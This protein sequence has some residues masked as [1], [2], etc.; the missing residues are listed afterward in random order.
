MMKR[1]TP[2]GISAHVKHHDS[3]ET[4]AAIL[5]AAGQIYAEYG[6]AGARTDAIAA[7][8]G[9]N[10]ALLYYYFQSKDELYQAV[11]GSQVREFQKQAREILAARGPAGPVLLRYVSY[12]FD[13]MAT[14]P[15]YPRIFQRMMMEGDP[16]LERLIREHSLPLK[17]LLVAVLA[18]GLKAGEFRDLDKAHTIVSI[19][20]LTAHYF[21][22][23]PAYRVITGQ[24]PY[25][26]ANLARR[27]AEV[28]K[29]I[30]NALFRD[31]EGSE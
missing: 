14:H 27:K 16:A 19:A 2:K 21:N 22:I 1:A 17:R 3:A 15:Q 11:V 31:P 28:L 29:F 26:K 23:A 13:F 18:R 9:V 20:G 25:S 24:D 8:A 4:R 30:R 5:K 7:A 6:L 12:H 10:K